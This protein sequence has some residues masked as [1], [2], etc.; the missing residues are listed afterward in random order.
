[1]MRRT[2]LSNPNKTFSDVRRRVRGQTV[3]LKNKVSRLADKLSGASGK[4]WRRQYHHRHEM[5]S[6]WIDKADFPCKLYYKADPN[7]LSGF[8]GSK[9]AEKIRKPSRYPLCLRAPPPSYHRVAGRRNTL[10]AE[11]ANQK[12]YATCGHP[13][14]NQGQ[15]NAQRTV[16]VERAD[17]PHTTY[18]M[19]SRLHL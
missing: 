15:G 1:M 3:F 12:S 18:T 4:K 14:F 10:N 9:S 11:F 2:V 8:G 7:D 16:L 13:P 6:E 17:T 19:H 5:V